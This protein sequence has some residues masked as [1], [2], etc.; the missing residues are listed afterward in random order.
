M[1]LSY[2]GIIQEKSSR[3]YRDDTMP[4]AVDTRRPCK[5]GLRAC[6]DIL[7]PP[8]Y[9][10]AFGGCGRLLHALNPTSQGLLVPTVLARCHPYIFT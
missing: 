2:L 3:I 8:P 7:Q 10:T 4:K 1:L 6:N 5:V 9:M